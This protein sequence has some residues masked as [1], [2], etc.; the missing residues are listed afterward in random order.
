F[1][2]LFASELNAI[3]ELTRLAMR[4]G[5]ETEAK[6]TQLASLL[7]CIH[8]LVFYPGPDG[9]GLRAEFVRAGG[10]ELLRAPDADGR[11]GGA[12]LRSKFPLLR[13]VGG[14]LVD[15]L[16]AG[17]TFLRSCD[18]CA[19]REEYVDE[20]KNCAK[21]RFSAYCSKLCQVEAWKTGGHKQKCWLPDEL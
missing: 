20:W 2:P 10:V 9:D 18:A 17:G 3:P 7:G 8:N 1:A 6:A 15:L 12:V 14:R 11:V 4:I 19:R 16:A 5:P 13:E 21:C